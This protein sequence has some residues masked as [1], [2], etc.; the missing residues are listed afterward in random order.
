MDTLDEIINIQTFVSMPNIFDEQSYSNTI[1]R[2]FNDRKY[3]HIIWNLLHLIS[4]EYPNIPT[5]HQKQKSIEFITNLKKFSC[6]SC[7][8]K[9]YIPTE[10]EINNAI[11]S[12][13]NFI[14]FLI[15]YHKNTNE[16]NRRFNININNNIYT[17]DTIIQKYKDNDYTTYFKNIYDI[18][19]EKLIID[20][21]LNLLYDKLIDIKNNIRAQ[22]NI[23]ITISHKLN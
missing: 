3:F 5:D 11:L 8:T 6:S 12:K 23:E 20:G 19:V 18:D 14:Q 22:K 2:C 16:K 13:N 17:V 4:V 21:N 1:N 9:K 10:N 15:D 7:G